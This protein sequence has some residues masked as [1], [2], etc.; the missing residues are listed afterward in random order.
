MSKFEVRIAL[1]ALELLA[2][3]TATV[4][5]TGSLHTDRQTHNPMKTLSSLIHFVHLAETIKHQN[6]NWQIWQS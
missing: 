3:S 1:T 6:T 5:L 2:F 4:W